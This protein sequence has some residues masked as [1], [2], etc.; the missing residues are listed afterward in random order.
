MRKTFLFILIV[1]FSLVFIVAC[2][3]QSEITEQTAV[4]KESE[5]T[6]VAFIDLEQAKEKLLQFAGM[7]IE[8]YSITY[9]FNNI[10]TDE[11]TLCTDTYTTEKGW[12]NCHCSNSHCDIN[13][14]IEF[15]Q[16]KKDQIKE[17]IINGTPAAVFTKAFQTTTRTCFVYSGSIFGRVTCFREDGL[18]VTRYESAGHFREISTANGYSYPFNEE[19]TS[20]LEE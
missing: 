18:L 8:A 15:D 9:S 13:P 3:K 10:R 12:T 17:E 4:T 7:K 19:I 20:K 2:E 16:F 5:E 14:P 1:L 6:F 11:S